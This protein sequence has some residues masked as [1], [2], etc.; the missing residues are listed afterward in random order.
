MEITKE[1]VKAIKQI[2][3]KWVDVKTIPVCFGATDPSD[4][5]CYIYEK[6]ICIFFDSCKV[7]TAKLFDIA[8]L[9]RTDIEIILLIKRRWDENRNGTLS[10]I[11]K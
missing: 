11:I 4:E 9:N 10:E 2:E 5:R 3:R 7:Y 1:V 6:P 8:Y